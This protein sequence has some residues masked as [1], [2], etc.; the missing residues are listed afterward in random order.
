MFPYWPVWLLYPLSKRDINFSNYN[1]YLFISSLKSV[2]FSFIYFG[3]HVRYINAYNFLDGLAFFLYV[4]SFFV[5]SNNL[6]FKGHFVCY[7]DSQFQINISYYVH[8]IAFYILSLAT[9][10]WFWN[11][12]ESYIIKNN[13]FANLCFLVVEIICLYLV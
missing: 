9:Y 3:S 13:H 8:R 6:C 2:I 5:S 7:Q 1:F 4:M 12:N 10:L 11:L